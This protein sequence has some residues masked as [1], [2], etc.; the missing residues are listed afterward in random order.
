ME[1]GRFRTKLLSSQNMKTVQPIIA[2]YS[3]TSN[4][5][6]AGL[7]E[8]DRKQPGDPVKFVEY[9][10]DLVR[11][12][13]IAQGREMPFRL[14]LGKDVFDDVKRKCE[15]TLKMLDDWKEVIRGT[16]LVE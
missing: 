12:E 9:V 4:A 16:D 1:P 7:M 15:E 2:D 5:R 3:E 10:L 13:G 14:P 6:I 11:A 8:G